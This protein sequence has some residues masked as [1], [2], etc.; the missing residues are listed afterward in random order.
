MQSVPEN[1]TPSPAGEG[2]T[3]MKKVILAIPGDSFSSKFLI[4]WTNTVLSL[5]ASPKYDI[6]VAPGTGSFVQYV[7]MQ[8]LGLDVGR[9]VDQKP[10]NGDDFDIWL[11]IDS[12]IIFSPEQ[13]FELLDS[14]EKHP[15]VS[16][17]YRMSDLQHF[18]AVQNWDENYFAKHRTYEF[19][20]QESLDKWKSETGLKFMPVN[21]VGLGFFACRKEVLYKMQY[22]YFDG[23]IKECI[24]D[25]G[26]LMRD[27]SS[28]DVCFCHNIAKAGYEIVVNT[29][30]RVGHLKPLV[31]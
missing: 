9:G 12:D 25:T 21:Y 28:E 8:T 3:K 22:P 14:T 15:A 23:E 31:I 30:L 1:T 11:T 17:V 7:R 4:S 20:T 13:I 16:G 10:F 27:N 2:T 24:S 26:V 29:D 6:A 18:A 5:F 19:L